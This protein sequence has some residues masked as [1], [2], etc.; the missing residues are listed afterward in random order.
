MGGDFL[1]EGVSLFDDLGSVV[2][3]RL[4]YVAEKVVLWNWMTAYE[5]LQLFSRMGG[6]FVAESGISNAVEAVLQDFELTPDRNIL[7][8]FLS[9]GTRRKLC[10]AIAVI[11]NPRV[12]LLESISDFLDPLSRSRVYDILHRAMKTRTAIVT[13]SDANDAEILCSRVGFLVDGKLAA[14]GLKTDLKE[15]LAWGSVCT[16]KLSPRAGRAELELVSKQFHEMFR[17][18]HLLS[19]QGEENTVSFSVSA[20]ELDIDWVS[21]QL[22]ADNI[23]LE[24]ISLVH[25]TLE[26]VYFHLLLGWG[27]GKR[28]FSKY[29]QEAWNR[30][31]T[32]AIEEYREIIE[33]KIALIDQNCCTTTASCIQDI[34]YQVLAF[35]TCDFCNCCTGCCTCGCNSCCGKLEIFSEEKLKIT[36]T[37]TDG[38]IL[39]L[40]SKDEQ[41]DL[42]EFLVRLIVLE[43][44]YLQK[45][46]E[47]DGIDR[48]RDIDPWIEIFHAV[49]RT[50]LTINR[51]DLMSWNAKMKRLS[52]KSGSFPNFKTGSSS[53][54]CCTSF[55][56]C[57]GAIDDGCLAV[58]DTVS[59]VSS[60]CGQGCQACGDCT[61]NCAKCCKMP[62]CPSCACLPMACTCGACNDCCLCCTQSDAVVLAPKRLDFERKSAK[63]DPILDGRKSFIGDDKL[64]ALLSC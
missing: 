1:I 60:S 22:R 12:L 51:D 28:A 20:Q 63:G 64:A 3:L 36:K 13:T 37:L 2:R 54:R 7:A 9:A 42:A 59:C 27:Q 52:N 45:Q 39:R 16:L 18:S 55:R 58:G 62:T 29:T 43:I 48:R 24:N 56:E 10:L 53:C 49:A 34:R 57:G 38:E 25:P 47:E 33:G 5:H 17:S 6:L 31:I 11:I 35:I 41:I 46:N 30:Y 23:F 26:Q 15:R 19:D 4:G 40:I 8:G 61:S 14:C 44:I 32:S 21:R 50:K